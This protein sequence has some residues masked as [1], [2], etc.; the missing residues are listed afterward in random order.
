MKQ[1]KEAKKLRLQQKIVAQ[2]H[3]KVENDPYDP[4]ITFSSL[5]DVKNFLLHNLDFIAVVGIIIFAVYFNSL[6]GA[7]V[8]DDIP[9]YV[10]NPIV[11]SFG[12]AI[13]NLRWQEMMYSVV[14]ALFKLNPIPL[15][16]ISVFLHFL[17]VAMFYLFIS[18]FFSKRVAM[19]S[20]ILFA[21]HP[22]ASETVNWIS[23]SN[24]MVVS[25]FTLLSAITYIIYRN[26]KKNKYLHYSVGIFALII[27]VTQSPQTPVTIFPIIVILDQFF[28]EKKINWNTLKKIALYLIPIVI[29][30]AYIFTVKQFNTLERVTSLRGGTPYVTVLPYSVFMTIRL[31]LFP[32]KLTLYHDAEQ[33]SKFLLM[34]MYLISVLLIIT[35][36]VAWKKN[37][38]VAGLI[39]MGLASFSFMLSPIQLSW[40]FAERYVYFSISMFAVLLSLLL[41]RIERKTDKKNLALIAITLLACAYSVRTFVR[42]R[43]WKT[44][45]SL[46]ES[47]AR[48]VPF[49]ARAYNNLGDVYAKEGNMQAAIQAFEKAVELNPNYADALHNL[50]LQLLRTD[51]LDRAEESFK[52]SLQINPDLYQSYLNLSHIEYLRGNISLAREYLEKSLELNPNYQPALKLLEILNQVP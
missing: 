26:S 43:D 34:D 12:L 50:G 25:I 47:T 42:N 4:Y 39:L 48:V 5:T 8:S 28:I 18:N 31:M 46:W 9:A 7:F 19:F 17:T 41:L 6:N 49:S 24:Y 36:L 45:K 22:L 10:N 44:R 13:K 30:F 52:K 14:Y 32:D 40:L 37:Q 20:S 15:H 3:K 16:L 35:I 11:K 23:A 27:L 2:H 21:T 1:K 29:F 38:K 33:I 51:R